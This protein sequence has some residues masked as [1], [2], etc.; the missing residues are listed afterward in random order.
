MKR[1]VFAAPGGPEALIPETVPI[2]EPGPLQVVVE[3][4]AIGVNYRDILYRSG[5]Y[6]VSTPS[7]IGEEGAGIVVKVGDNVD[8]FRPGDRVAYAFA[9]RQAYAEFVALDEA[10]V[11]HRPADVSPDLA[12]AVFFKGM[13]AYYLTHKAWTVSEN[14]VVFVNAAS[15]GV[16]GAIVRFAKKL[17]AKVIGQV[18]SPGKV[19]FA[20]VAGCDHVLRGD[21]AEV[22]DRVR[23]LTSGRGVDAVYDAVGLAAKDTALGV[24]AERAIW[25]H[26]GTVSGPITNFDFASLAK[27]GSLYVTRPTSST[28]LASRAQRKEAAEAVWGVIEA[29]AFDGL[30][31]LTLP[32]AEAPRVHAILEKR[33]ALG[34]AILK[35]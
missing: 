26:Y 25:I 3:N 33:L 34:P 10:C 9:G 15:G 11:F 4:A 23:E 19:E 35:P 20:A 1:M 29:G 22:I 31:Q 18:G 12:A 8:G 28:Y 5:A 2:P 30:S 14:S 21:P 32:L 16:G 24:L 17:G 13:T 6:A 7:G 27:H